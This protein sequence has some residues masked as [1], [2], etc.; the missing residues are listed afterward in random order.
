MES[1]NTWTIIALLV[2]LLA[3]Y[4]SSFYNFLLF[5]AIAETISVLIAVG[6]FFFA[7]NSRE[8]LKN[9]YFLFIG[10][11]YLFVGSI[12]MVHTFAYKGMGVFTGIDANHPTQLWIA[13]RYLESISLLLAFLFFRRKLN[14]HLL[15]AGLLLITS[16]ILSSIFYWEIFPDCFIVGSGLT[17]FKIASEYII[18]LILLS[19]IALLYKHRDE[20]DSI[21]FRLLVASVILTIFAELVFTFYVSVFGLSN[22]IGHLFK[23]ISFYLIYKAV[24]KTGLKKPYDLLFRNLKQHEEELQKTNLELNLEIAERK[25][26]QEIVKESENKYRQMFE[27]NTAIKLLIDPESGL[28]VNA[29]K[30][31]LQFYGYEGEELS[32]MKITDINTLSPEK[33]AV[34]MQNAKLEKRKA[35]NFQHRLASGQV[36]DVEVYSGPIVDQGKTLLYSIIHDISK[37]KKNENKLK[38][39]ERFFSQMFEQSIVSTQLLDPEGNTIRVNPP[40]CELF[41]V[42]PEDMKHYKILEDETI[43]QSDAYEPLL[44]VFNKKNSHRWFNSFDIAL[45]S[46]SSGVST[47][48]PETVW[49][50]NL[51][52]PILDKNGNL[53]YAVIQ[54]HNI[55]EK[56]EADKA[57]QESEQLLKSI[58]DNFPNS[59]LSVINEDYTIGWSGGQEFKNQGIDPNDFVG[60]TLEDV[61]GKNTETVR[62]YYD[63]TFAGENQEF[64]LFANEQHQLYRTVA[65]PSNGLRRMVS[66][67]ENITERKKTEEALKAALKEKQTM[68]DEIHHR[69]KNNMQIM[70][71]LLSL[72]I[73]REDDE[74]IKTVLRENRGRVFA[75]SAIHENLVMSEHLSEI[76]FKSYLT[77]LCQTLLQTYSIEP[78][79]IT[80][81]TESP[82]IKLNIDKANPLSLA[83]NE[84]ISN[85]LKYAFPEDREGKISVSMKKLDNELKLTVMDD[86]VGMPIDYDW[87]NSKSLGLKLV[88]TLVENQLDGSIDMESKHGTKFTIKFNIET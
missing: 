79:R 8:F 52:Y 21:I 20:F 75:I 56:V 66:V 87:K 63:K 19:V 16:L 85:S 43:K 31:A 88:R 18:S 24:I 29:N 3:I 14:P 84:L 34:E 28:I 74:R 55:T 17:P 2:V 7:W 32:H 65:L 38:E 27:D 53:Q 25:R 10:I 48:K 73:A 57:L 36:R 39:S 58:T 1:K 50:E 67:V 23:I 46:E 37:R 5:H 6:V 78:K 15:F 9:N 68:I 70:A 42:T 12:D 33:V 81:R 51:S 71:S 82:N 54:H 40:F 45:A 4:L 41:G 49:L 69:V 44:D 72:Q 77:K 47:T 22:L 64:E 76:D 13:A 35:F 26:G 61:F 83:V 30:A 11:A 62:Q 59:F 80:Y 86:G 60:L